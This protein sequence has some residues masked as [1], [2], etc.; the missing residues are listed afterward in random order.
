MVNNCTKI[1]KTKESLNCDGQQFYQNQQIKRKFKLCWL[2][3]LP[4]STKQRKV[5]IV[6]VNN[7]TKIHKTWY[8]DICRWKSMYWLGTGTKMWWALI[9][10][11]TTA[12]TAPSSEYS[13]EWSNIYNHIVDCEVDCQIPGHISKD[14]EIGTCYFSVQHASLRTNPLAWSP[15]HVKLDSDKLKLWKNWFEWLYF[16]F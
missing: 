1:N 6:M 8:H 15:G 16:L 3:I 10:L 7:S 12:L 13:H 14:Y 5:Y 11:I 9:A 4:K 2:A